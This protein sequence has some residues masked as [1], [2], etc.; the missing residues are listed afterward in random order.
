MVLSDLG[1][2]EIRAQGFESGY[3]GLL[4]S[5]DQPRVADHVG[6]RMA[7][8]RRSTCSPFQNDSIVDAGEIPWYGGTVE[9]LFVASRV[10]WATGRLRPL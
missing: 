10:I 1:V 4:I 3:R 7:A 6:T 5:P 8:R 9:C 2:D